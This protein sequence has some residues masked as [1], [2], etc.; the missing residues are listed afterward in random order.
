MA[1][2][3]QEVREDD[4]REIARRAF[5]AAADVINNLSLDMGVA[6]A[7]SV[8]VAHW[9]QAEVDVQ[10]ILGVDKFAHIL[11]RGAIDE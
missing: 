9:M 3:K 4:A 11:T 10:T 6:L 2:S 8:Q 5:N 1:K 7:A